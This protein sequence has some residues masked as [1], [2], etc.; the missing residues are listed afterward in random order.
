MTTSNSAATLPRYEFAKQFLGGALVVKF[1]GLVLRP[2]QPTIDEE[3]QLEV[4]ATEEESRYDTIIS[5]MLDKGHQS[6][7]DHDLKDSLGCHMSIWYNSQDGL[8]Q[9]EE[10]VRHCFETMKLDSLPP[11]FVDEI[12]S[13]ILAGFQELQEW[14]ERR[15]H[16]RIPESEIGTKR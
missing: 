16:E 11:A 9:F 7:A 13:G 4:F 14:R 12:M 3:G 2:I 10:E 6:L 1:T 15:E 8:K 5:L